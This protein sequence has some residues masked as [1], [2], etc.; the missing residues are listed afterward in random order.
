MPECLS[1]W[2]EHLKGKTPPAAGKPKF[3]W[4]QCHGDV[5][6]G[7][8]VRVWPGQWMSSEGYPGKQDGGT[9]A[10]V[11]EAGRGAKGDLSLQQHRGDAVDT[12]EGK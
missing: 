4:Y 6:P 1:F 11:M 8:F 5:A 3:I 2:D 12:Q 9:A 10:L 7:P